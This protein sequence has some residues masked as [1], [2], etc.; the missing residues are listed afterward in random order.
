MWSIGNEIYE[1]NGLSGGYALCA[2]I[3]AYVRS[4]DATRPVTCAIPSAFNGV[5]DADMEKIVQEWIST[6]NA[7]ASDTIQNFITSYSRNLWAKDTEAFAA[8]LDVVGYNYLEERY[9][10]D[11]KL[12]PERVICG[13]ESF[14]MQIDVAWGKVETLPYVIGDFAWAAIDYLGEVGLG[15]AAYVPKDE[16]CDIDPQKALVKNYPLRTANCCDFDINGLPMPQLAY[17]RIV[18]GS[19][20]TFI[21][22]RPPA[23]EG[24]REFMTQWAWPEC[25]NVWTFPGYEGRLTTVDVYSAA[26]EVEL[27][28]NGQSVGTKPVGKINRYRGQ[29]SLNYQRGTLLAVSRTNGKEVSRAEL[30]TA[31]A[32]VAIRLTAEKSTISADGNGLA[33][34][35]AE[36]IDD[37][38]N[39]VPFQDKLLKASVTG[40]AT[41]AAFGTGRPKTTENYT[42]GE[43]T[44]W[45]GRCVAILR[46]GT[47]IGKAGLRVE[48]IGLQPVEIR[49]DDIALNIV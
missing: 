2:E 31:G 6:T 30:K 47:T 13:Q 46:S 10:H 7:A 48:A 21:A 43:F 23:N 26:D 9:E 38:G 44:S 35:I 40:E 29:F 39:V 11:G 25:Y 33:Y 42:A 17:R 45:L 4:L 24:K 22:A 20:E 15:L 14:P 34:I 1:R 41:L 18:W 19:D 3:T 37:Q 27:F 32:I 8:P 49:F 16:A 28:L 36:L 5:E 12:F